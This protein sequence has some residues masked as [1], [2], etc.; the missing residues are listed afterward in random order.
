MKRKFFLGLISLTLALCLCMTACGGLTIRD[1]GDGS[2][3]VTPNEGNG[4]NDYGNQQGG[5]NQGSTKPSAPDYSM[6]SPLLQEVLND[7]QRDA[8]YRRYESGELGEVSNKFDWGFNLMEAIPYNYIASK[9]EEIAEIKNGTVGVDAD[10]YIME[11][12]ESHIYSILDIVY[13]VNN[14]ENY[15]NQYLLKYRITE[16]ELKDLTMLYSGDYYQGPIMFQ[17]LAAKQQP[18]VIAEF[19][20]TEKAYE[21]LLASLNKNQIVNETFGNVVSNFIITFFFKN[22]DDERDY[23]LHI[24]LFYLNTKQSVSNGNIADMSLKV[25]HWAKPTYLNGVINWSSI[26]NLYIDEQVGSSTPITYF[27]LS[28]SFKNFKELLH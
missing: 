19:S 25:D 5:N 13:K 4:N 7:P 2:Y 1:N 24:K 10:L 17:C 14:G 20:I 15:I 8:L 21:S 6:Y 26:H 11:N 16:Q 27:H 22:V 12:D 3:T 18:E 23:D 28:H 9:D